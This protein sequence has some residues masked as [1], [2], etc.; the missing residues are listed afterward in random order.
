MENDIDPPSFFEEDN[1]YFKN[2]PSNVD[3]NVITGIP[4]F[5]KQ[6]QN[7]KIEKSSSINKILINAV[8]KKKPTV[9]NPN[10]N[11]KIFLKETESIKF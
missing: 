3:N 11:N 1:D 10:S 2:M 4:I 5:D 9:N 7:K 6:N 8:D